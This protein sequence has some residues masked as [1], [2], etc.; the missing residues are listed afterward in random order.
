M[1]DDW[2]EIVDVLHEERSRGKSRRP[3]DTEARRENERLKRDYL[4]VI[5]EG[6]RRDFLNVLRALGLQEG[7][8]EHEKHL[9]TWDEIQRTRK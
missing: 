5:R 4:K 2:R 9:R 1:T 7:S 3:L 6:T 8:K